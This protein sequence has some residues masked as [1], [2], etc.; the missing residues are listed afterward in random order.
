MTKPRVTLRGDRCQCRACGELFNSTY[1]FDKHRRGPYID[2]LCLTVAAMADE[3]FTKN[4]GGYW[5][6]PRRGELTHRRV[7]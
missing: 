1:A 4:A 5:L 3:G 2:R 6:S 7:A